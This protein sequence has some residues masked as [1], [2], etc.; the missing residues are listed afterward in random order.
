MPT[1]ISAL[2]ETG[3]T[4]RLLGV[5][6]MFPGLSLSVVLFR[7]ILLFLINTCESTLF[8]LSKR[9]GLRSYHLSMRKICLETVPTGTEDSSEK[10]MEVFF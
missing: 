3:T 2:V 10:A 1:V 4:G 8:C 5:S 7:R 6:V 9:R